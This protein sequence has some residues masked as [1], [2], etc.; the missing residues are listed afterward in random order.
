MTPVFWQ[1]LLAAELSPKRSRELLVALGASCVDPVAELLSGRCLTKAELRAVKRADL[2]SLEAALKQGVRV[3]EG[4]EYPLQLAEAAG[5]PPALFY[6][7]EAEA[8]SEPCIAV[9]GTRSAS[10]YGK[11]VARKFAEELARCG[12]TIV[13]G[14]AL[15]IDAQAHQGAL[16]AGGKTVA[17][18]GNG[19]ER[20]HP[21][22]NSELLAEVRLNGG[23]LVSQFAVASP[24]LPGHFPARNH[25]IAALSHAVLVVEAPE[26]SGSIITAS[27]AADL[28]RPLFVVPGTINMDGFRGSHAL[29]RDGGTLVD[30]PHQVLEALHL[31]PAASYE[32]ISSDLTPVQRSILEV[33]SAEPQAP[34]AVV[35]K[36]GMPPEEVLGELTMLE[37]EGRVIREQTGYALKP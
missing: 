7:G 24:P 13:S 37:L 9:V 8:L 26:R 27:A 31:D 21:A 16:D 35:A 17:V 2:R 10:T 34:E 36:T 28:G 12:A 18:L 33:L 23:C 20:P 14:G 11:A 32:R 15:G 29:I 19:V 6:W 4:Q 30:H 5:A 25:L 3:L 1:Y 22:A